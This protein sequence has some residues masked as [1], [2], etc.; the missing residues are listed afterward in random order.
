[1]KSVKLG[2]E[3]ITAPVLLL[4][5]GEDEEY[6]VQ[7]MC[8]HWFPARVAHIDIECVRGADNFPSRFKALKVRS[9][10]PLQIVG[11]IADSEDDAKATA[12][13]WM[14]LIAE[15]APQI[16]CPCKSLQLPS[17]QEA[18][19]FEALVLQALAAD[20][21]AACAL[22]FRDCVTP[23]IG[24][25]TL[26]QKDKIAVQAWLSASLGGAYG[27]VFK[28]QEKYP[29]RALLDY[30]HQAFAPIKQFVEGLLSLVDDSFQA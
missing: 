2:N 12:Q 22:N 20:P 16:R 21:V 30:D 7:K 5:E 14:D 26:A 18:G 4:V 11:I 29:Q 15:V 8:E 28:A 27:N 13:R 1:M 25:R 9:L 10:G 19:A 24:D 3:A 17:D 6:L 23:H